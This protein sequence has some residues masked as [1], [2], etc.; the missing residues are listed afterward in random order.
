[1]QIE[2]VQ[3]ADALRNLV[4]ERDFG[5]G[6]DCWIDNYSLIFRIFY[7]RD[8]FKYMQ[9]LRVHPPLRAHLEFK[10][11]WLADWESRQIY[12]EMKSGD[13][14]WDTQVQ[15]HARVTMVPVICVSDKTH[16]TNVSSDHHSWPLYPTVGNF[17][18]DI[19]YTL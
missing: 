14:W 10:Q 18:T 5:L 4:S 19:S 6:D 17:P 13:C 2:S 8:V 11:V 12:C 15:L 9:F 16:L 1:M 7:Y 3:L